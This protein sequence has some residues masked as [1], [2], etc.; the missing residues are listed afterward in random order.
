MYH[1]YILECADGSLYTGIT[2]N[3]ELRFKK[4]KEGSGAK[5]T[6][7]RG[8]VKIMYAE[9]HPSRSAAQRREGEIKR[10]PRKKKLRLV[11][12]KRDV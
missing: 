8:A 12:I 2:N 11:Q 3:L 4:H 6:R 10:W 1:L 5:Y 9:D 7:A